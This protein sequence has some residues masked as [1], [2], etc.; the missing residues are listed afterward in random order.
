MSKQVLFVQGAGEGAHRED[1]R[2]VASLEEGLGSGYEIHYPRL[3]NEASPDDATWMQHLWDEIER[4]GD[5]A[6]LV[7]HSAG[8][9]TLLR[10][11]AERGL[12]HAIGGIFLIATPFC[13]EGGWD[14]GCELPKDLSQRLP[15][16]VPTILYHGRD[17]EIVPFAH[18]DQYAS[19]LPT[20]SSVA[21]PAKSST[22]R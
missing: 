13:G 4:L 22:Q 18:I 20:Q 17:D 1:A 6:I 10:V 9:L 16:E 8:G 21:W 15:A 11:L 2:L 3:P 19:V 14:E 12:A 7:G 5:G